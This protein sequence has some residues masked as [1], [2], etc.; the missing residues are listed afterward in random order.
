MR[1]GPGLT[2]YDQGRPRAHRLVLRAPVVRHQPAVLRA[3]QSV[4]DHRCVPGLRR[5]E[6][7]QHDAEH[8]RLRGEPPAAAAGHAVGNGRHD[9]ARR[10]TRRRTLA[11]DAVLVDRARTTR[12]ELTQVDLETHD[13]EMVREGTLWCTLALTCRRIGG[14]AV[15][16]PETGRRSNGSVP[17][18]PAPAARIPT[19]RAVR[20]AA[21]CRRRTESPARPQRAGDT[22]N[23]RG[24]PRDRWRMP[25]RTTHHPVSIRCARAVQA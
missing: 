15:R 21:R 14:G 6:I 24:A 7:V 18:L 12:A 4:Q 17:I 10:L 23:G 25:G 22:C 19:G 20:R 16:R 13:V 3:D 9:A 11:G 8:G 5:A 2:P 1:H